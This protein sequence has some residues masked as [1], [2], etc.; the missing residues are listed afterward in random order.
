MT[1]KIHGNQGIGP[2][3]GAKRSRSTDS[4]GKSGQAKGT[5]QVSF[6]DTL[7]QITRAKSAGQTAETGRAEKIQ[8]LKQQIADGTYQPDNTKVAASLLNFISESKA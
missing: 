3:A 8:A 4:T 5:D 6:S 1:I 7:Q 2:L